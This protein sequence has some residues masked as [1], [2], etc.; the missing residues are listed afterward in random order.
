[1]VRF[2][3]AD[4]PPRDHVA[5]AQ[6]PCR[7]GE[8]DRAVACL[9]CEIDAADEAA[10]LPRGVEVDPFVAAVGEGETRH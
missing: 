7:A 8:Q 2:E 9:A 5:S 4:D 10:C 1:M 6:D 3:R